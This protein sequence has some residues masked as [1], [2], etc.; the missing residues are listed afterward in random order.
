MTLQVVKVLLIRIEYI[1][2]K[3]IYNFS[4]NFEYNFRNKVDISCYMCKVVYKKSRMKCVGIVGLVAKEIYLHRSRFQIKL[5]IEE[6]G[7]DVAKKT[8]TKCGT[9]ASIMF[10]QGRYSS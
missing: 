4:I 8:C 9:L 3:A 2:Y 7:A 10:A 6:F 1:L 5:V